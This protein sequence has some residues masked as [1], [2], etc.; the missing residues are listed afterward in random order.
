MS[1]SQ[2]QSNRTAKR[3]AGNGHGPMGSTSDMN[4]KLVYDP[5]DEIAATDVTRR[6]PAGAAD[7]NDVHPM[8]SEMGEVRSPRPS[9]PSKAMQQD[10]VRPAAGLLNE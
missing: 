10:K 5:V 3:M 1:N 4:G 9:G 2:S 7:L 8:P 6:R